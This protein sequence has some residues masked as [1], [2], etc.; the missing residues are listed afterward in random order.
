MSNA[1]QHWTELQ[2]GGWFSR[3][4]RSEALA[5]GLGRGL[6]APVK[7]LIRMLFRPF[8]RLGK[9]LLRALIKAM[10]RAP[11]EQCDTLY[12]HWVREFDTLTDRDRELIRA[13]IDRL[14]YKPLISIIMPA[15]E[16]PAWLLQQSIDSVRAQLYPFWELCVADDASPSP[17]VAE[18][19]RCAA[20]SDPRIKWIRRS[21]NGHISAASN[22]ALA[23]ASGEFVALMDHDDLLPQH[24]LYEVAACLNDNPSLDMIYSD[25]DQIDHKGRRMTPYFKT[26]W[27]ATLILAHNMISHLGVYRRSLLERAGGFRQGLEGSQDYDVSLRCADSTTPDRIHH[28]PAILYHWRREYGV[29]SFSES[30]LGRC[31]D[32]ALQ[33][34]GEHLKRNGELATVAVDAKLPQ[35]IRVRRAM[36]DPAPLVSLIVPTRDHA[37]LLAMC[38][39]GILHRTD[40]PALELLIVDHQSVS[41]D[42]KRLFA[43]LQRD[44]RV[45]VLRFEG[46]FNYSAINNMAARAAKGS[47]IGLVNNDIDV[48]NR[49]WLSEMVSIAVLPGVGAVGAKLLYP[50]GRLQHGGVVLGVGGVANHFNHGMCRHNAGYFGRNL[51][52]SDVSAVTGACLLVR[53]S[54]FDEVGGL[55]EKD[56]AVAFNDVDLC[57]KILAKGYRN[58]WTPHAELYH[59][60]SASRGAE[61]TPAKAARFRGEVDYMQ[62]TWAAA[63]ARDRFYNDNLSVTMSDNFGLAFPARRQKPWMKQPTPKQTQQTAERSS[64]VNP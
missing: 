44:P 55:N 48:I 40:Y 59:H 26:D 29:A 13:H 54:V 45:R 62:R 16:T 36:P 24:A 7:R 12:D 5:R 15:Y 21:T 57:L 50:D 3:I 53:K 47:I 30:N 14:D 38:A 22:S 64:A 41:P 60:E 25:E 6:P 8:Y 20:E 43:Q 42:T 23:L 31:S 27:N 49:D 19:L 28:I 2:H 9:G 61:D 11:S 34:V 10:P 4:Q 35:W 58:V 39:D 63:L 52:A 56:L 1:D 17:H 18:F 32:A 33:A 51:L 46:P 37:E